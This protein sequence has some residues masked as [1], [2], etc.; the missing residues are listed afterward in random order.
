MPSRRAAI[1][2]IQSVPAKTQKMSALYGLGQ[3]A[4]I[5]RVWGEKVYI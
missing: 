2:I 5:F 1:Q 4:T 3:A